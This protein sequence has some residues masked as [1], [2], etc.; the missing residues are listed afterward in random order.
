MGFPCGSMQLCDGRLDKAEDSMSAR[1][2][3]ACKQLGSA[4]KALK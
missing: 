1:V 2:T 4:G 3:E